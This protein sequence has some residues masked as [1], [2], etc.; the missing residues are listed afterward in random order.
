M[1]EWRPVVGYEGLYEVSST[2]KV[3]SL[4]RYKKVLKPNYCTTYPT[5][6]LFKD[7]RGKC[8]LIH[9]L[10]AEAFI[11]NPLNLPQVNHIDENTRNFSIENLEWCDAKYNM[12][13]GNGARTRHTK[14]DYSGENRKEIARKNGKLVC[15]AVIQS[16]TI[17][18]ESA[19][20]ASIKT[21]INASHIAE[22]CKHKRKTAGGYTWEYEGSDDLSEFQF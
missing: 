2:G 8:A 4:F 22:C 7:G 21:G 17:R 20:E 11:P 5:V 19:K 13:Y 15:K 12:N 10:V 9:R 3:K 6:Q 14:I 18:Y 16:S 1:E